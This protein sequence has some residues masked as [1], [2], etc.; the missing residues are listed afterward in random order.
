MLSRAT[1]IK[2]S[3]KPSNSTS[4]SA[5]ANRSRKKRNKFALCGRTKFF[6][7]SSISPALLRLAGERRNKM[8]QF[9][10]LLRDERRPGN[11]FSPEEMQTLIQK[12]GDWRRTKATG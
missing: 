8:P 3:R 7:P 5:S 4:R 2:R 11:G 10:L 9:I 1:I 12:Y 6:G